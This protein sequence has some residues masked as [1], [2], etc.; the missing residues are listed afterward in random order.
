MKRYTIVLAI[1][2]SDCSGGAGIQADLKTISA[3]GGYAAAAITAVT[4][5]NTCGVKAIHPIPPEYIKGQIEAVM[6]DLRPDAVKIGMIHDAAAAK[7]I[8]DS[9]RKYRPVRVVLDPVMI[10]TSGCRLVEEEAIEIIRT[11]LMPMSDLV[12]PN[13]KEAEVLW[14]ESITTVEE[15]EKAASA[16]LRYGSKAVLLK[17]GHLSGNDMTDILC[18]ADKEQPIRYE[19]KKTESRNTHGTGCTLSSAIATLLAQGRTIEQAAGEAKKYVSE[20]IIHGKE[21]QTGNG[22]GPLNHFFAP[23]PM[24]INA[25]PCE[26]T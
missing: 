12:T 9:L 11:A 14:G 2:G 24:K 23:L 17:G 6:E 21:V 8:A 19:G 18:C 13:L 15:M 16:L 1:A 10:S 20:G 26:E 22:H 7:A 3:L 5:Q 4:V 25:C